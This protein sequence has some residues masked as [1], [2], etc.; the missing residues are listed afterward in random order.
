[1]SKLE[2]LLEVY[3]DGEFLI[4]DGFDEAIVGLDTDLQR[5]VY[6]IDKCVDIIIQDMEI[7]WEDAIEHFYYNVAGSY[8][9]EQTPI[10]IHAL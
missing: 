7:T 2:R 8:V 9:G 10:F 1:M 5:V 3:P 6:S 4:A